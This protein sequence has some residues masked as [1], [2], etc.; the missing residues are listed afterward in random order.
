MLPHARAALAAVADIRTAID[1]LTELVRGTVSIGTVDVA[2]R[3]S[4]RPV[5]GLPRRFPERSRSPSAQTIPTR[6]SKRCG[7]VGSTPRSSRSDRTSVR[8]VSIWRWSPTRPSKRR[9]AVG[10]DLARRSSIG[11]ADLCRPSPH[12]A[13]GRLRAF[14]T[15]STAACAT[16]GITPRIAFEASTP[17]ALADLAERGLGVAI[18]P[19][20][21]SRG[22]D[23]PACAGHRAATAGTAGAGLAVSR[24]DEPGGTRPGR[25]GSAVT[26]LSG[27]VHRVGP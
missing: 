21:V 5:G 24:S 18:V 23:G 9:Y 13:A 4:A 17:E 3:R 10:D 12:R 20:S 7:Q 1:E 25:Q 27:R 16:A 22:R 8:R 6:S 26:A 11:L 15:S 2:Q 19:S 14:A